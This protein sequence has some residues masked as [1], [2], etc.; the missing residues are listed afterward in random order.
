MLI[1]FYFISRLYIT[2]L[3]FKTERKGTNCLHSDFKQRL[4]LK[5]DAETNSRCRSRS[6]NVGGYVPGSWS[7]I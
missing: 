5:Y 4:Q 2:Y 3:Q 1:L 7:T 6:L